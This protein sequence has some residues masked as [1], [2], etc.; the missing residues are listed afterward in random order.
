VTINEDMAE[1]LSRGTILIGSASTDTITSGQWQD[2]LAEAS[3]NFALDDP[4]LSNTLA[5]MATCYLAFHYIAGATDAGMK[6]ENFL[7]YSYT[8]EAGSQS[9]WLTLYNSLIARGRKK[10]IEDK[11]PGLDDYESRADQDMGCLKLDQT[12]PPVFFDDTLD[13]ETDETFS[14]Y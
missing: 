2:F 11:L 7:D 14:R 4:G 8:R 6:S 3:A 9:N 5:E 12:K 10:S 1:R 13:S